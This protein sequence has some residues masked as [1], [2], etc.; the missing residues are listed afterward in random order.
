MSRMFVPGP[1]DVD[2]DVLEAQAK[3]MIPHRSKEFDEF[4]RGTEAKL[5]KVFLKPLR[6]FTTM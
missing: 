2:P 3:P 5:K 1:V 4:F 6:F